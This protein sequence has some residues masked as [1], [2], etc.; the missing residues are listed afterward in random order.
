MSASSAVPGA[1]FEGSGNGG[2]GRVAPQG[3]RHLGA[4]DLD[5]DQ[6]N[7]GI[8]HQKWDEISLENEQLD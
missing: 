2:H 7:W 8:F 1:R 3:P 4:F 6:Q 5:F